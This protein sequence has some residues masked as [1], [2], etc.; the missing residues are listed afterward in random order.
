MRAVAKLLFGETWLLPVGLA[1]AVA[2]ALVLRD[3]L[4]DE[5]G[6]AGGFVLLA[7]VIVVLVLSVGTSSRA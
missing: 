7:G 4:G 6:H 3:V 2:A 5:W 1:V